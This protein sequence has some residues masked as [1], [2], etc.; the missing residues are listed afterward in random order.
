MSE[1]VNTAMITGQVQRWPMTVYLL[2]SLGHLADVT[3]HSNCQSQNDR[4]LKVRLAKK[5][6]RTD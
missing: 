3:Q 2:S 6:Y 5:I 1:I 4:V